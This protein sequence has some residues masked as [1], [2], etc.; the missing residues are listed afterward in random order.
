VLAL[1]E[2]EIERHYRHGGGISGPLEMLQGHVYVLQKDDA[3]YGRKSRN[4]SKEMKRCTESG[5]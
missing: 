2:K 4:L 3:K 1:R 5:L